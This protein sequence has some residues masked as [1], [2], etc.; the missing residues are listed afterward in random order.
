MNFFHRILILTFIS[1]MIVACTKTSPLLENNQNYIGQWKN[2][3]ST[4]TIRQ[5]GEVRWLKR[6]VAEEKNDQHSS[7]ASSLVDMDTYILKLDQ[8]VLEIGQG[9]LQKKFKIIK[10]PYQQD[11]EWKMVL[12]GD[13]FFK[14]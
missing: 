10:A 5:D 14:Q 3:Y 9:S 2:D 7:K 12:D 4:L 13:V 11:G 1:L 8:N 6:S